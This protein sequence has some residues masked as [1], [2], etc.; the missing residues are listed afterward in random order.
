M[1]GPPRVSSSRNGWK[2]RNPFPDEYFFAVPLCLW[3]RGLVHGMT[4]SELKR[5][6]TLLR[7]Y[8][9]KYGTRIIQR[10]LKEFE[11]L[12]GVSERRAWQVNG[13]LQERGL[14]QVEK[15]KPTTY[16][17]VLPA[18]WPDVDETGAYLPPSQVK[19]AKGA[20]EPLHWREI[21]KD[22]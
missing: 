1:I 13:K 11:N 15:T 20:P 10:S 16:I 18:C 7:L 12:D 17:L 5:Y 21:A 8:N 4:G 22:D 19:S 2:P 9:Y 6:L 14:V 3:D